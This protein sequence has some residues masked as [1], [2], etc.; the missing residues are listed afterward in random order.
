MMMM[1]MIRMKMMMKMIMM[2]DDVHA[3]TTERSAALYRYLKQAKM[4]NDSHQYQER[5]VIIGKYTKCRI[6]DY[7][8]ASYFDATNIKL[9]PKWQIDQL[10]Q[11]IFQLVIKKQRNL[12][13]Y[14]RKKCEKLEL[15]C[16][17]ATRM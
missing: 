16:T 1:M 14:V 17:S 6:F 12:A 11:T 7:T 9:L 13:S 15:V 5:I 3:L 2:I 10:F 8:K 4:Y